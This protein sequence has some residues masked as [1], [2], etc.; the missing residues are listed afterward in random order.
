MQM[1]I[2]FIDLDI[3]F[4]NIGVIKDGDSF[5]P[6]AGSYIKR[7]TLH[8]VSDP[9]TWEIGFFGPYFRF[10]RLDYHYPINWMISSRLTTT[11]FRLVR[12]IQVYLRIFKTDI[13][14]MHLLHGNGNTFIHN[15]IVDIRLWHWTS[16]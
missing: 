6:S 14:D 1:M 7:R 11:S 10:S 9:W 12:V 16:D 15:T 13:N 5:L 3:H 2:D 8:T 4:S